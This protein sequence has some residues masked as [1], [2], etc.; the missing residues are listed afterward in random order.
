MRVLEIDAG[1]ALALCED[2]SGSRSTIEIALVDGLAPG[3]RAARTCRR[4]SR[5]AAGG[6]GVNYV[7]EFR[8]GELG[9]AV[10]GGC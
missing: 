5:P 9:R 4:R 10:A 8:D 6:P 2:G 3:R 1:R 7:E